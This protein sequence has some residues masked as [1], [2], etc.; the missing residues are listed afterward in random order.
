MITDNGDI[1][2]PYQCPWGEDLE[3]VNWKMKKSP[4]QV[5]GELQ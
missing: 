3:F 2:T 1:E 5:K 4:N